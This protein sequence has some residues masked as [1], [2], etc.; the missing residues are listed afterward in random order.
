MGCEYTLYS[1]QLG[2]DHGKPIVTLLVD[3]NQISLFNYIKDPFLQV[4]CVIRSPSI[5]QSNLE[6]T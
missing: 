5:N 2:W 6:I 1:A 3:G 4:T